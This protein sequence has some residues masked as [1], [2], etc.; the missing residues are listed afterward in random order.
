ML[1]DTWWIIFLTLCCLNIVLSEITDAVQI[2]MSILFFL[3]ALWETRA[4]GE[5][6]VILLTFSRFVHS[7]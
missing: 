6:L 4:V 3:Q 2:A 7:I 1:P 5:L